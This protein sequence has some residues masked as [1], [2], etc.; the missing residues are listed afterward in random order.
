MKQFI[1]YFSSGNFDGTFWYTD[2]HEETFTVENETQVYEAFKEKYQN[3]DTQVYSIN[4]VKE[5]IEYVVCYTDVI[6]DRDYLYSDMNDESIFAFN[7]EDAKKQFLSKHKHE[8]P[9]RTYSIDHIYTI[10][11][12]EKLPIED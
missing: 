12:L 8:A 9:Y 10:E 3:A 2:E 1:V 5:L 6:D 4:N 11:E 7:K